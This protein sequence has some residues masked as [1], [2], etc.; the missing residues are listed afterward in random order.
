MFRTIIFTLLI[1]SFSA[2]S[3]F[4][5]QRVVK[6][7]TLPDYAPYCMAEGDY[8]YDQVVPVGA[9]AVG[10]KGYSWD[11]LRES[12]HAM[13]YTIQ[14][15]IRPWPRAVI[16]LSEAKV[17]VLFPA[18]LNEDRKARFSYSDE[19]INQANFVIYL[20]S[21][22]DMEWHGLD[23]VK[24]LTIGV[25]AEFNYGDRWR[26]KSNIRKHAVPRILQGFRMLDAGRIDGFVGYEDN[27]DYTLKKH[28]LSGKFR[29]LPPFDATAEYL[30]TR[31]DHPNS[32]ELLGAFDRGKRQLIKSGRFAEIAGKWFG[33]N[34]SSR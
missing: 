28:N 26:A 7:A 16:E 11:L 25:K 34:P 22:N 21:D 23:G 3:C 18:G 9:D 6:V 10:F 27:W 8:E 14:L 31:K 4:A 20:R 1:L 32:E 33:S 24:D 29:K 15:S 17:D 2:T 19:A 30:V 12:Y 5:E 13:G